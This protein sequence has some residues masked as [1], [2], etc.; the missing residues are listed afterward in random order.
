MLAVSILYSDKSKLFCSD[1]AFYRLLWCFA[2][3]YILNKKGGEQF[4][5]KKKIKTKNYSYHAVSS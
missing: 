5:W 1:L 3:G 4:G 2:Q